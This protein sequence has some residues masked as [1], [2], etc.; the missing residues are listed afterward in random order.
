MKVHYS[1]GDQSPSPRDMLQ[2]LT[3][4]SLC[5]CC[6]CCCLVCEPA[7]CAGAVHRRPSAGLRARPCPT[8]CNFVN[9]GPPCIHQAA[10]PSCFQQGDHIFLLPE[11]R[12]SRSYDCNRVAQQTRAVRLHVVR[13][14]GTWVGGR[15]GRAPT[16][17]QNKRGKGA[18]QG[19]LW[20]AGWTA[21]LSSGQVPLLGQVGQGK[22]CRGLPT[23]RRGKGGWT[24]RQ[25]TQVAP[26]GVA[27]SAP[28]SRGLTMGGSGVS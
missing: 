3:F 8:K 20:R 16:S 19:Q 6:C 25:G 2:L 27:G 11:A 12:P 9:G 10:A 14:G 15:G 28:R 23:E 21:R 1:R 5:C 13:W 22:G 4:L 17:G 26:L 24:G 18:G 7:S